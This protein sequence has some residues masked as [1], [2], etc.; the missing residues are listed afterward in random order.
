MILFVERGKGVI[1]ERRK[2]W[3]GMEERGKGRKEFKAEDKEREH[4]YVTL[5]T[6]SQQN[7]NLEPQ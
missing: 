3:N 7:Y 2:E 6:L 1:R 5:I 4:S